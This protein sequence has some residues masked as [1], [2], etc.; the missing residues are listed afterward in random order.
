MTVHMFY[1]FAPVRDERET[2]VTGYCS[3]G[4]W[5]SIEPEADNPGSDVSGYT[6]AGEAVR[7]ILYSR[8]VEHWKEIGRAEDVETNGEGP[9]W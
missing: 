9:E 7:N 6:P 5:T 1:S 2:D 4:L 8:F 3:C